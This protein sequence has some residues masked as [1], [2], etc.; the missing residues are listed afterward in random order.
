MKKSPTTIWHYYGIATIL[1]SVVVGST[2]F[3]QE[4]TDSAEAKQ[5]LEWFETHQAMEKSSPYAKNKWQFVGPVKMT[6]RMTDVAVHESNPKRIYI[7]SA[8]GGVHRTDDDGQSWTSI[9][10]DHA[11]ASIGDIALDPSNTDILW[12]GT[13][14]ANILRSSMAGTGIYKST[15]AGKS[16]VYSG[17][18]D[19]QHIARVIVHPANSDI[20]YVASCG[21]EYTFSKDRGVYKTTDGGKTWNKVFYKDEKTG[22]IDLA[23]DPKD[24]NTLYASTA[25]R[26]RYR[27]ND[28]IASEQSGLYKST[29]GGE[30]WKSLTNGLPNLANCERIGLDVCKSNPNVVYALINNHNPKENGRG[31]VGADLY[32]SNDKGE[33]WTRTSGSPSIGGIFSSYGW[34][35]GQVRVDPT[36]PE[37]V[38]VMGLQ[39]RA[40][41]DGGKTFKSLRGSHVDYHAMWI[42]PEDNDYL[43]VANDGG[44][45]ISYDKFNSMTHPTN[46]GISQPYNVGVSNTEGAF[47]LY[48]AVQDHG[49]HRGYVDL[50]NGR[51][52]IVRKRWDNAPG[53]E[54]GRHAVDQSDPKIVYSVSRY[55][56]RLAKT[57]YDKL[58]HGSRSRGRRT[59][60]HPNVPEQRA[61][62]VSPLRLSPHDNNRLFYGAQYV[63]VTDDQGENWKKIS[64]DLTNYDP[65]KQGNIAYSTVFA[66]SESPVTKGLI[67]AGTDDGNV[68]VTKNGGESWTNVS[69]GLPKDHAISS[70]E[71][72]HFDEGTVY[73]TVNGKRNDTFDC[74]IYKSTDYGQNWQLISS[75]IP[76]SNANVVKQDPKNANLLYVGTDRGV[77]VTTNGG[78]RWEVLGK[79]LPTVYAHDLVVQTAEDFVVIATHGRGCWVLDVRELRSR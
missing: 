29:D 20:V 38:Y 76:G 15:D 17:L 72:D 67:Y 28:P 57:V 48:C 37:T 27:W 73:I 56:G 61:Q 46:L 16:F 66:I 69:E 13:G 1:C 26:L 25:Q 78:K 31:V 47:W 71:A 70:I 14:E 33:S 32:R 60:I 41:Y 42:N 59:S 43:V 10:T 24:P 62:W 6:G 3:A 45:M 40:S 79:G 53:D 22:V 34:V 49:A 8:S 11:S 68:Q 5:R 7:A 50:S 12:V 23:M 2:C 74:Q 55:G 77:Y 65:E 54:S 44:L 35:F 58:E 21:H 30:T 51:N 39:F 75:N 4:V 18:G 9:F 52:S 19:T 64:D 63:Y 36:D